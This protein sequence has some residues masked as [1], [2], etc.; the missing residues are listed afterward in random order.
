MSSDFRTYWNGLQICLDLSQRSVECDVYI[1]VGYLC[2]SVHQSPLVSWQRI[3]YCGDARPYHH[4]NKQRHHTEKQANDHPVNYSHGV[5]FIDT[6]FKINHILSV[7]MSSGII[8]DREQDECHVRTNERDPLFSRNI[9]EFATSLDS[10]PV[11]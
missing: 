8:T 10:K 11:T 2:D 9:N 1:G 7:S 5:S 6:V 4:A 3:Q